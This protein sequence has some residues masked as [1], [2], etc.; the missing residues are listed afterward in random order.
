MSPEVDII[1]QAAIFRDQMITTLVDAKF[2]RILA[3][4]RYD[5]AMGKLTQEEWTA[6]SG[7][8]RCNYKRR[9]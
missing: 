4:A 9:L 5:L 6:M 3:E 2:D 1:D 7:V 8:E